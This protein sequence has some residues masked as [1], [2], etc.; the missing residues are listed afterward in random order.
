MRGDPGAMVGRVE[1]VV[2]GFA[3]AGL[4]LRDVGIKGI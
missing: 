4:P 2:Y 3:M 1:E